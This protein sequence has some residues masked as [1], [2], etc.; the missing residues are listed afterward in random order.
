MRSCVRSLCPLVRR[1]AAD[2]LDDLDTT[3]ATVCDGQRGC[4]TVPPPPPPPPP[5]ILKNGGVKKEV[6]FCLDVSDDQGLRRP[7]NV[8]QPLPE[9]VLCTVCYCCLSTASFCLVKRSQNVSFLHSFISPCTKG[10]TKKNQNRNR[11]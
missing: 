2:W 6:K 9:T 4:D 5:V 8:Y 7:L 3:T 10:D 1:S 11:T